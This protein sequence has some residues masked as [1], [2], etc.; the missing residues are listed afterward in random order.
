MIFTR[1]DLTEDHETSKG[2]H[3]GVLEKSLFKSPS[4]GDLKRQIVT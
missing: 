1:H 2:R 3:D 4:K